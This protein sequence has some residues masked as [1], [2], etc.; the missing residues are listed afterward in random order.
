M[1]D[2]GQSEVPRRIDIR[3]QKPS[4]GLHMFDYTSD[5]KAMLSSEA[6]S[7][8]GDWIEVELTA[9]TGVCDTVMPR[10]MAQCIPIQPSLQS[11]KSMM[12]EVA[13]GLAI[14]NLGE[15]RCV[16]WT[17][18]AAEARKI[19]LQLVDFHKA[20]LSLSRCADMGFESR[21]GS[22]AGVL[23]DE[24]SG[25]VIPMQRKGD[26]YVLKCWLKAGLFGRPESR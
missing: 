1:S 8:E 19:N 2:E 11:L 23:I 5:T 17:E 26:L 16:M 15:L 25:E 24:E 12:Y 14:P 4:S 21:S 3:A 18:N 22:R 13:D 7:S 20:I 10:A 9:D 6:N